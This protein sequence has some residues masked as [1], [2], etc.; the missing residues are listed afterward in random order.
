MIPLWGGGGLL[1]VLTAEAVAGAV[2]EME[3]GCCWAGGAPKHGGGWWGFSRRWP[4][5][6]VP[7]AWNIFLDGLINAPRTLS[8]DFPRS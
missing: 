3:A 4:R 2:N 8:D 6:R 1:D 7:S 5:R